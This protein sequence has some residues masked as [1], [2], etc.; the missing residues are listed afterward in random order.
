MNNQIRVEEL[1]RLDYNYFLRPQEINEINLTTCLQSCDFVA[2]VSFIADFWV[3]RC[4]FDF[5]EKN[6]NDDEHYQ[7]QQEEE[8]T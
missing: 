5:L 4:R 1:N 7:S 6:I 3:S 8:F 2:D